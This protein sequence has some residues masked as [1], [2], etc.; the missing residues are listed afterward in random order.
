MSCEG[1]CKKLAETPRGQSEGGWTGPHVAA[2][3]V[4]QKLKKRTPSA[5]DMRSQSDSSIFAV[6]RR[7]LF[8]LLIHFPPSH[9]SA[10][11]PSSRE[12]SPP[13]T[14]SPPSPPS[15]SDSKG[16][17]DS[18]TAGTGRRKRPLST[19]IGSVPAATDFTNFV[20]HVVGITRD[21]VIVT[22]MPSVMHKGEG[23]QLAPAF[24]AQWDTRSPLWG[25]VDV[26]ERLTDAAAAG[27]VLARCRVC[28]L[29]GSDTF[30]FR[31]AGAPSN[32]TKHMEGTAKGK[33]SPC[34]RADHLQAALY[35][36]KNAH[37]GNR[38]RFVAANGTIR[39][40]MQP[41]ARREHHLR[42]VK[43]QVMKLSPHAFGQNTYV[44]LFL[45]GLAV[46]RQLSAVLSPAFGVTKAREKT[47][48]TLVELFVLVLA[49]RKTMLEDAL[50]VPVFPELPL[51][52]GSAAIEKNIEDYPDDGV[53][54]IDGQLYPCLLTWVEE[55]PG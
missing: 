37:G 54:E 48:V 5:V 50:N 51:A 15:V 16:A 8:V 17:D 13:P 20:L 53:I 9:S 11:K 14:P 42:F 31:K 46:L 1:R 39:R 3:D 21:F 29:T 30:P 55:T 2:A 41:M 40:F 52:V 19:G 24:E 7:L 25:R 33:A 27:D 34:R 26:Y 22:P 44:R 28:A 23:W 38:T 45:D 47:A 4:H 10:T 18:D 35:L 12:D 32:G 36:A 6:G 43:M 49:L